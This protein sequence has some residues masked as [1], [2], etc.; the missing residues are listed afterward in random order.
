MK[1]YL[2]YSERWYSDACYF[3]DS[4]AFKSLCQRDK[5]LKSCERLIHRSWLHWPALRCLNT[6]FWSPY[7][8]RTKMFWRNYLR[9]GYCIITSVYFRN[10]MKTQSQQKDS[11]P[12]LRIRILM[13]T[14]SDV[15]LLDSFLRGGYSNARQVGDIEHLLSI[16]LQGMCFQHV[17]RLKVSKSKRGSV[18]SENI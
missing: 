10:Q 17:I 13:T 3:Y 12:K 4:T 1:D 16:I 11:S 5:H 14:G 15:E 6:V 2:R 18:F 9:H 8:Q 7:G